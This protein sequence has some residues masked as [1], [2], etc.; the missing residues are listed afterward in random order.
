MSLLKKESL[1]RI[2]SS[3]TSSVTWRM[4]LPWGMLVYRKALWPFCKMFLRSWSEA[5]CTELASPGLAAFPHRESHWELV[6]MP[7]CQAPFR[8]STEPAV[9]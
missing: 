4:A 5:I 6:P 9:P 7:L 2:L 1:I 3:L 8:N